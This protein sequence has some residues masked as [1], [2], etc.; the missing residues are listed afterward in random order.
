MARKSSDAPGQISGQRLALAASDDDLDVAAE[1]AAAVLET[2]ADGATPSAQ[3]GM[4]T[5][6]PS[7]AAGEYWAELSSML[8]DA[9]QGA[10]VP[11]EQAAALLSGLFWA[12]CVDPDGGL[13]WLASFAIR[14]HASLMSEDGPVAGRRAI[15]FLTHQVLLPVMEQLGLWDARA[16]LA[17]QS[18]YALDPGTARRLEREQ[19]G[20]LTALESAHSDIEAAIRDELDREGIRAEV[21]WRIDPIGLWYEKWRKNDA[22]ATE[23]PRHRRLYIT[24]ERELDCYLVIGLAHRACTPIHSRVVPGG[25]VRDRIATPTFNGYRGLATVLLARTDHGPA[26]VDVRVQTWTM[27]RVNSHGYAAVRRD[28]ELLAPGWWTDPTL[29][30]LSAL[31]P[32][33]PARRLYV[34]TPAGQI[35]WLAPKAG[36]VDFAFRIHPDIGAHAVA[37]ICNGRSVAYDH[38]LRCADVVEILTDPDVVAVRDEWK[39]VAATLE[40]QRHINAILSRRTPAERTRDVLTASVGR[41]FELHGLSAPGEQAIAE[42]L[43]RQRKVLGVPTVDDLLADLSSSGT[44]RVSIGGMTRRL[45]EETLAP[46][47]DLSAVVRDAQPSIRLR[48]CG[49]G[50]KECRAVAGQPVFAT[51]KRTRAGEVSRVIIYPGDCPNR[52]ADAIAVKW[53]TRHSDADLS[54]LVAQVYSHLREREGDLCSYASLRDSLWPGKDLQAAKGAMYASIRRLRTWLDSH[55]APDERLERVHGF[56]VRYFGGRTRTGSRIPSPPLARRRDK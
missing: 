37:F 1:D 28:K 41:E 14:A 10:R 11:F 56:G 40:A 30:E 38:R 53:R 6:S 2:Y 39:P 47:L 34:F 35:V 29:T 25:T 15:A 36:V 26:P 3:G 7:G 52:P 55:G 44:G 8:E 42:F 4:G 32:G 9:A 46:L 16:R 27:R 12:V 21:E 54:P 23:Y 51:I 20:A 5:P 24:V 33:T 50:D 48:W 49:H 13:R 18:A 31:P 22:T 43:E 19:R 17:T 45:I